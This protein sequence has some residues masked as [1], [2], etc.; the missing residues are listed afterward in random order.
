MRMRMR[1][2]A[3]LAPFIRANRRKVQPLLVELDDLLPALNRRC[4]KQVMPMPK[5]WLFAPTQSL[6]NFLIR[7]GLA[8]LR[9]HAKTAPPEPVI[10][11]DSCSEGKLV[12][13]SFHLT[14]T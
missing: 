10:E 9:Q 7:A 6:L 1:M 12:G 2:R 13:T 14:L 11:L 4:S 3:G 5:R 8:S